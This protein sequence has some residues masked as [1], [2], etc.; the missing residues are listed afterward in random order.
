M[1]GAMD[2]LRS[3]PVE[4]TCF[5]PSSTLGQKRK[6]KRARRPV[7]TRPSYL[8]KLTRPISVTTSFILLLPE[9]G[10]AFFSCLGL[11]VFF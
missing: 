3:K 10:P 8:P 6:K 4:K 1:D 11:Y 9:F 2:R 5:D 7:E